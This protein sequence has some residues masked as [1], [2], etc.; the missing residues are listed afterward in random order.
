MDSEK[1]TYMKYCPNV[2]LAKCEAQHEKGEIINGYIKNLRQKLVFDKNEKLAPI[3]AN[4][5]EGEGEEEKPAAESA[6]EEK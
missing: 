3:F 2:F 6:P 5:E 1:I 4:P